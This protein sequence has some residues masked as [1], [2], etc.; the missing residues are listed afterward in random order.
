VHS[1]IQCPDDRGGKQ[2]E[3]ILAP[4]Q[5][6]KPLPWRRGD[7]AVSVAAEIAK[8]KIANVHGTFRTRNL[9]RA[10]LAGI[11]HF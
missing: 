9:R 4:N 10:R 7:C 1:E 2:Q 3:L 8:A 6:Y 11:F 5:E